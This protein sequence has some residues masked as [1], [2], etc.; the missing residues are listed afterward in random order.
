MVRCFLIHTVC[1]VS[2]LSAGECRV[3]YSR[4]FGPDE[5]LLSE[6]YRGLSP[7]RRLLQKEKISVVARCRE[8]SLQLVEATLITLLLQHG[9]LLKFNRLLMRLSSF[10]QHR[11]RVVG[12]PFDLLIKS[13]GNKQIEQ[14][15]LVI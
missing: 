5:A 4:L 13:S 2:A 14:L 8:C 7:E 6:R 11:G 3:L 12:G 10:S 15:V 9:T 1:P